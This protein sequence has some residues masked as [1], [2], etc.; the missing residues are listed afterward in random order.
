M[1]RT[2]TARFDSQCAGTGVEIKAVTADKIQSLMHQQIKDR[3]PETKVLMLTSFAEDELLFAAIRAG[4]SGYLL[5]QIA[6]GDVMRWQPGQDLIKD[7][8]A[9]REGGGPSG[10]MP[11]IVPWLREAAQRFEDEAM[12][13]IMSIT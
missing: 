12:K 13:R 1:R 3:L 4:A 7:W 6:G 10:A 5:K 9:K 11:I 2:A 8:P